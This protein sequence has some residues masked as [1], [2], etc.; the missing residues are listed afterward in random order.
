MQE[1]AK[2][3]GGAMVSII[4]L[5]EAKVRQLCSKASQGELLTEVN[6]NCPGQ[7]VIS[8]TSAACDRAQKLATEFGA[9]KA[10]RL[11]VAGAFHTEM[12]SSAADALDRA[13][14][15]T[16]IS[17]PN[18]IQVISNT[19]SKYYKSAVMKSGKN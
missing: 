13:L 16:N 1:A 3:K 12:M 7:I 14:Q 9:I 2:A 15:S 18:S 4:G 6:F 11:D 5:D 17:Q 10:I 8:G 19:D